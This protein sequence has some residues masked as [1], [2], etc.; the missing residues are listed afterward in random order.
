MS[1]FVSYYRTTVGKKVVMAVTGI[2]LFLFVLGHMA[3]NLQIFMGK[4]QLRIRC[5]TTFSRLH[6]SCGLCELSWGFR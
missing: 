6:R 2:L 5:H 3:G 1:W 4:D